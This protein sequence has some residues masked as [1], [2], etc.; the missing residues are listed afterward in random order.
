MTRSTLCSKG[1]DIGDDSLFFSRE[2]GGC[3]RRRVV[4]ILRRHASKS[5]LCW[6]HKRSLGYLTQPRV[7]EGNVKAGN[8]GSDLVDKVHLSDPKGG[9]YAADESSIRTSWRHFRACIL[10][11]V[12]SCEL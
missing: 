11:T 4:E 7:V 5:N 2:T 8:P 1:D 3:N 12:S 6:E 10:G 9:F